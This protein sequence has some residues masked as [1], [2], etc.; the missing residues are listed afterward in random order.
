M[1]NSYSTILGPIPSAI[2]LEKLDEEL[3]VSIT[4]NHVSVSPGV[5]I[6]VPMLKIKQAG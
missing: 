4:N 1:A 2:S 6:P 5:V 3:L